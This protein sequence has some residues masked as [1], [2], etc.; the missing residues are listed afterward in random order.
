MA[1][2]ETHPSTADGQGKQK[3][4]LIINAF[5]EMCSGHQSPGLWRHPKD[6][7]PRYKDIDHWVKLA[8][9]FEKGKLHGVFIADVL[10]GYDVYNG[11]RNLDAAIRSGAQWPVN[12]PLAVIPAMAA[13]TKSIG[14][15]ATVTTTYEQPYHLARRLST[16]DHLTKGRVGWNIVTGYL[17]SAARN[18]GH[19]EQPLHAERYAIA[20][21]YIEVMYKLW[22]SSWRDDAVVLD[23]ER[24]VYSEPSRIREIN[25]VGKYFTV[26]GPHICEP[27]PQRTPLLLQAGTSKAGKS[28]AAKHAEGI[29]MAGHSPSVIAKNI[30]E[31]RASAKA[32]GRDP[33]HIKFLTLITPVLGRTHEEAQQ[34]FEDYKQYGSIEG[35]L[36]LFGG[37]TGIDLAKYGDDEE[38]RNVESNAIK[39]AVEAWSKSSPGVAK[40]TKH[41]VAEH[42]TVGG[43][44]ATVVGT[45]AEVADEFE[46]WV[47]EADV[48]GFNI[49]YAITPGS[50]E[51]VVELLLPE[52]RR[53]GLFWDDYAVPG[54]TYREN[55]YEKKGQTGLLLDHPAASYRWRAGEEHELESQHGFTVSLARS[56]AHALSN[57]SLGRISHTAFQISVTSKIDITSFAVSIEDPQ[58]WTIPP[59]WT[60]R[61]SQRLSRSK[62]LDEKSVEEHLAEQESCRG[63]AAPKSTKIVVEK[64]TKNVKE[65]H[66]REIFGAYGSIRD[67]DLPINR[68]FMTNRG[69]AYILYNEAADAESAIAH[70]HEAQLDGTII[71]VSIVLSKRKFSRSPPPARRG[72]GFE[73]GLH[74]RG[75]MEG[76]IPDT[77]LI[78]HDHIRDRDPLAADPDPS[79]PD[80]EVARHHPGDEEAD[81][82]LLRRVEEEDEAPVIVATA[83]TVIEVE[84][85]A[86]AEVAEENGEM[87]SWRYDTLGSY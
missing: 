24:G 38:L 35:A 50:F 72:P 51:D 20:E 57:S 7:S 42:I 64:L 71:N 21:E 19:T 22:E 11:P 59:L 81:G 69:T 25:H 67:L 32:L 1:S 3:K 34:K 43:L 30:A 62:E 28:F 29:F 80:L 44:G 82:K 2:T 63:S 9:L 52:L 6:Q 4:K 5:V 18:L 46:R 55:V 39:S 74:R 78:G 16:I 76:R 15:G 54:G 60:G 73:H 14:F 31:V 79:H 58:P 68:Q 27:S 77:I 75:D 86:E 85:E 36:A 65:G 48:D 56:F 8:Q 83:A 33:S 61:T 13:A 10:G 53:R 26:P 40:W 84:V 23:R 17:D 87:S 49:A 12:E 70:M 66:L 45:A 41:T 37:W 47:E